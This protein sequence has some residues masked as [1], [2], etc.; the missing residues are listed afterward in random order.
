MLVLTAYKGVALIVADR[1]D[2]INKSSNLLAQPAYR[3]I[4]QDSTN[5]I[6]AK[7]ITIIRNVK[8]KQ[9]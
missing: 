1:Q 4:P 5:K 2:Y 6:K 7:P 9:G 3:L 8:I